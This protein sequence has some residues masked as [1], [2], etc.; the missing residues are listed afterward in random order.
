VKRVVA[1]VPAAGRSQRFGDANKLLQHYGRSTVVGTVV[2]KLLSA[3][4]PVIVVTGHERE[5]IEGACPGASFVFNP[6]FEE[7]IGTSVAAGVNAA[8]DVNGVM[9]A[10]ADMP[11]LDPAAIRAVN[12]CFDRMPLTPQPPPGR[13]PGRG[14]DRAI[15]GVRYADEPDRPGHP[16]LYGSAY[17]PQLRSL[18]GDKGARE[19]LMANRQH[20][21]LVEWPGRLKDV[22]VPSDFTA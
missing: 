22:D 8:G 10:L 17:L 18:Q 2:S 12:D 1:I 3:D 6:L 16:I 19:L 4:L 21:S 9:I 7:G 5:L 15:V 13:A 14:G 20:W 11:G